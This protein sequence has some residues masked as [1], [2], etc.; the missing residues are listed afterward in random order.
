M[1]APS[2]R[3]G[4]GRKR[5]HFVDG[6]LRCSTILEILNAYIYANVWLR[7]KEKAT[8]W[9]S[10][11]DLRAKGKLST[12]RLLTLLLHPELANQPLGT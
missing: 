6:T 9:K 8:P 3:S 11:H 1:I 2:Q 10:V 4:D 12:Y 5:H 7:E